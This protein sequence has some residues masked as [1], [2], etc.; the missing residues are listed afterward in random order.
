MVF[1]KTPPGHKSLDATT[2][3][4]NVMRL[5]KSLY[6]LRRSPGNWFNTIGDSLKDIGFTA[7]ASDLF[8][9]IFGSDNNL[10][11]LAMYVIDLLLLGGDTTLLKDKKIQLMDRLAMTDMGDVSMVLGMKITRERG[12]KPLTISQGHYAK[13]VLARLSMAECNPVGTTGAE[14]E[15]V[16]KHPDMIRLDSTG[17]QPYQAITGSLMFLS[18][19]THYD[20]TYAVNQLPRAMNEPSKVHMTAA[21]EHLLLYLKGDMGLAITYTIWIFELAGYC[22]ASW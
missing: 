8:L 10:R 11:V 21:K 17:I 4:P 14:A 6:G 22:D 20:I 7:T 19:C 2:G 15:L 16:L 5:M 1:V 9:Y 18:Q 13:S 12:T 3:R